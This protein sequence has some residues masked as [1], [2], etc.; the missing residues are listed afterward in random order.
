MRSSLHLSSSIGGKNSILNSVHLLP[1]RAISFTV[2]RLASLQSSEHNCDP[3]EVKTSRTRGCCLTSMF[4]STLH[5]PQCS[6]CSTSP[7]GSKAQLLSTHPSIKAGKFHS[8]FHP[9]KL[10]FYLS[11]VKANAMPTATA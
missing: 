1:Q 7:H 4:E 2:Q 5:T 10:T 3:P 9:S 8:H 6:H 11:T